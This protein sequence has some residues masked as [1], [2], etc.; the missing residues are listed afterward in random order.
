MPSTLN[1]RA[2][3]LD[4]FK[5]TIADW[6]HVLSVTRDKTRY[7]IE[8]VILERKLP[9]SLVV[10]LC[11]DRKIIPEKGIAV[12]K[13]KFRSSNSEAEQT[14]ILSDFLE[15]IVLNEEAPQESLP[16]ISRPWFGPPS[17]DEDHL[18]SILK[19]KEE[20]ALDV[21]IALLEDL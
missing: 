8:Q 20:L 16:L 9:S 18:S 21:I 13:Q 7:D 5:D 3:N 1:L 15:L 10:Q 11:R 2:F 12:L 4:G 14:D 17:C 19:D 6:D